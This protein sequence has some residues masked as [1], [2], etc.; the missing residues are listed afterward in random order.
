MWLFVFWYIRVY[1]PY[2]LSPCGRLEWNEMQC[3]VLEEGNTRESIP[4]SYLVNPGYAL[5]PSLCSVELE[6][7]SLETMTED[8]DRMYLVGTVS[9]LEQIPS[10]FLDFYNNNND[11]LC[12]TPTAWTTLMDATS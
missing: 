8:N 9:S 2:G 7:T 12:R 3:Q 4:Y 10:V 5:Q 1:N 11:T 6:I